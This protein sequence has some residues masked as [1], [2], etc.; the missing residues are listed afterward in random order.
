MIF[1]NKNGILSQA[2]HKSNGI[3]KLRKYTDKNKNYGI[4]RNKF[5]GLIVSHYN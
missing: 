3:V 2:I 5:R 4:H 1:V